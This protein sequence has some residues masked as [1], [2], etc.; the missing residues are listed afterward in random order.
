MGGIHIIPG[1]AFTNRLRNFQNFP[2][3]PRNI[4]GISRK[5][6]R[7][8]S[9]IFHQ[10]HHHH[11]RRPCGRRGPSISRL[12]HCLLSYDPRSSLPP[13]P[14]FPRAAPVSKVIL[15]LSYLRGSSKLISCMKALR[16]DTV[17]GRNAADEDDSRDSCCSTKAFSVDNLPYDDLLV[18][19]FILPPTLPRAPPPPPLLLQ[20]AGTRRWWW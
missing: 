20:K 7:N 8:L 9:K 2:K 4:L 18:G 3:F 1:V 13:L 10:P 14:L 12:L 16:S 6:S 11:R 5:H 15:Y 17:D 19:F